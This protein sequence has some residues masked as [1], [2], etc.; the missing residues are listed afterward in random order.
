MQLGAVE[1]HG[2]ERLR[3][4]LEAALPQRRIGLLDVIARTPKAC[5][6][7]AVPKALADLVIE[8]R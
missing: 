6:S 5:A 7:I 2:E 4:A 1:E 8:A 3:S